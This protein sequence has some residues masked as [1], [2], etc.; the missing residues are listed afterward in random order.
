[1]G[2]DILLPQ[3][4]MEQLWGR[5]VLNLR[6]IIGFY[7]GFTMIFPWFYHGFA[8]ILPWFY[9]DFTMVLP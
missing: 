1:L 2:F 3:A 4:T 6:V 5:M 7:H 9:H 8:M